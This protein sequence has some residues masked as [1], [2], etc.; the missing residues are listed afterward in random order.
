MNYP[1]GWRGSADIG[2]QHRKNRSRA[3]LASPLWPIMYLAPRQQRRGWCGVIEDRHETQAQL[4]PGQAI[5]SKDG[6][7]WRWDGFVRLASKADK[8]G[9]RIRQRQRLDQLK[10]NSPVPKKLNKTR[11]ADAKPAQCQT[12]C[13]CGRPALRLKIWK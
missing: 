10:A 11:T 1:A 7:L 4:R 9:E 3:Q 8:S 6:S 2:N 12:S 5:T 13:D